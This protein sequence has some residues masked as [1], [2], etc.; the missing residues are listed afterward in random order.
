MS[1]HWIHHAVHAAA[2][3][4]EHPK[5]SGVILIIIG[6]FLTPWMIGIPIL[7]YGFYKLCR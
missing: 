7:I 3:D 4:K 5:L 1:H 2:H 6:L